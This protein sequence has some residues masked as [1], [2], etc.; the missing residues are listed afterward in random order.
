MTT[1]TVNTE[2]NTE[3]MLSVLGLQSPTQIMALQRD[4]RE[5]DNLR[6]VSCA[7][8]AGSS[9]TEHQRGKSNRNV[10]LLCI[11]IS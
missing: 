5:S 2:Y 6:L 9:D 4:E 7:L 10:F 3:S 8:L 11:M 1:N